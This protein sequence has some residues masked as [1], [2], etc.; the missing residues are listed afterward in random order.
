MK[1]TILSAGITLCAAV[2]LSGCTNQ[3]PT[4]QTAQFAPGLGEIMAQTASRHAKLWF[5]GQAL[6]F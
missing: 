3:Q 5:A 2:I 4:A 6:I 1:P